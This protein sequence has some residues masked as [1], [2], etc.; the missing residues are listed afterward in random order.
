M[1][2]IVVCAAI[3]HPTSG[4]VICGP[5]H[6]DCLNKIA[7]FG[8]GEPTVRWIMGFVDQ[9]NVFMDR[10]E[11]WIVANEAL[12]IRRPLGFEREYVE[13]KEPLE[14]TPNKTLYGNLLFSE[15]LY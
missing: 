3:K 5:R 7:S 11:A 15:N 13:Q 2:R 8:Q 1:K 6:G 4:V 14:K 9:R 12:Q 10:A